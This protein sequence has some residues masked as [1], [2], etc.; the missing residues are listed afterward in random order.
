MGDN[1]QVRI[2]AG[3]TGA[4]TIGLAGA[5]FTLSFNSLTELAKQQGLSVP[6]LFPLILEGGLIVFSLTALT[7]SLEGQSTRFQ[8]AL[9]IGSSLTAMSFN[10]AHAPT[11]IMARTMWAIPSMVLLLAFENLLTQLRYRVNRQAA[12]ADL[13]GLNKQ[14][15][16]KAAKV[17]R[18]NKDLDSLVAKIHATQL[19]AAKVTAID[20]GNGTFIPG[21]KDALQKANDT[22]QAQIEARRDQVLILAQQGKSQSEI[23]GALDVSLAT[24]KRDVKALNG[25]LVG[26]S[27]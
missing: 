4:L 21:D 6:V 27:L 22:R 19:E 24:V 5:A 26:V 16:E 1:K 17:D 11:S 25:S 13:A 2:I 8:W 12:A 14:V 23:A 10:I 7:R 3:I 15:S 18:L 9:V 20:T